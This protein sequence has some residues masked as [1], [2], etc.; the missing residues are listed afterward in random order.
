MA[1]PAV[2]VREGTT[3]TV[4]GRRVSTT[5]WVPNERAADATCKACARELEKGA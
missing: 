1:K 5:D 3:W 4:C 2:H